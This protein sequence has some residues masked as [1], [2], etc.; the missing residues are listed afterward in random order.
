LNVDFSTCPLAVAA[1]NTQSL[2]LVARR[3][4]SWATARGVSGMVRRALTVFPNGT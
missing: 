1:G 3:I 2:A 4:S